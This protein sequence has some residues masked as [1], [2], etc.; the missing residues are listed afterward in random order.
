MISPESEP[1]GTGTGRFFCHAPNIQQIPSGCKAP[2]RRA[3]KAPQ[4][5]KLVKLDYN[6]MELRACASY[7]GELA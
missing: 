2:I 4:G 3:F 1:L 5:R 6:Q 7:T